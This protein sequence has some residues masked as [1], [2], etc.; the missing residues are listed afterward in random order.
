MGLTG[1]LIV[2]VLISELNFYLKQTLAA[3]PPRNI[4]EFL[5]F[6]TKLVKIQ[7]K[8]KIQQSYGYYDNGEITDNMKFESYDKYEKFENVSENCYEEN[9]KKDEDN[10]LH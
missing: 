3:N 5:S 10:Y 2:A 6:V 4:T 1:S 8:T 9:I 7:N